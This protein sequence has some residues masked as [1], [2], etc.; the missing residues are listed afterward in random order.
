MMIVSLSVVICYIYIE[1][2]VYLISFKFNNTISYSSRM[3]LIKHLASQRRS[4]GGVVI[5]HILL[6]LYSNVN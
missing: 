2:I 3:K 1:Y 5:Y 4:V 6:L